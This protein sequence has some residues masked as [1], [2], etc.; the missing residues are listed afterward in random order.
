MFNKIVL[1]VFMFGTICFAQNK[2]YLMNYC[3]DIYEY[4][5]MENQDKAILIPKEPTDFSEFSSNTYTNILVIPLINYVEQNKI[6]ENQ[7]QIVIWGYIENQETKEEL[8]R[9]LGYFL[10]DFINEHPNLKVC[11]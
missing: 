9:K 1:F 8:F 6:Q 2:D 11:R 7:T 10:W 5:S 3:G 4:I